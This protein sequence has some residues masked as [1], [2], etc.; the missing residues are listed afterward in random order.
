MNLEFRPINSL[1]FN[2]GNDDFINYRSKCMNDLE[3]I[4]TPLGYYVYYFENYDEG[5]TT[6]TIDITPPKNTMYAR[7]EELYNENIIVHSLFSIEEGYYVKLLEVRF[8][9][10]D[11][12]AYSYAKYYLTVL[13]T[14]DNLKESIEMLD[15]DLYKIENKCMDLSIDITQIESSIDTFTKSIESMQKFN[16]MITKLTKENSIDLLALQQKNSLEI[17]I[18]KLQKIL[19]LQEVSKESETDDTDIPF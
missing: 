12:S 2:D 4:L 13:E 8:K 15:R 3:K 5:G 16:S 19:E 1:S 10:K 17:P 14:Y 7:S 6:T 11:G 18:D 9:E